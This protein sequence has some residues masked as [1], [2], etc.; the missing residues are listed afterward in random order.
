MGT[1]TKGTGSKLFTAAEGLAALRCGRGHNKFST[2]D[3]RHKKEKV[4][5]PSLLKEKDLDHKV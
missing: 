1:G 5:K 2:A 4:V 3:K